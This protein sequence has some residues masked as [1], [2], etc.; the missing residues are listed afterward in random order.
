M[1]KPINLTAKITAK[2]QHSDMLREILI[3]FPALARSEK[4]CLRYELFQSKEADNVFFF[5]ERWASDNDLQKHL[6]QGYI[7]RFQERIETLLELPIEMTSWQQL[8]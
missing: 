2:P 8:I 7:Q 3:G 5:I 4:G 6:Q 1:A